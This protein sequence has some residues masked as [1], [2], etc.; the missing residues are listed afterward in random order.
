MAARGRYRVR[1]PFWGNGDSATA[2]SS[3]LEASPHIEPAAAPPE[4]VAEPEPRPRGR[5]SRSTLLTQAIATNALAVFCLIFFA[6]LVLNVNTGDGHRRTELI[7]L[8]LAIALV[9]TL[10]I[11]LLR[12]Q[13]APLERLVS[14]MEEIDLSKPG[15]RA[16]KPAGATEDVAELI[17]SFNSMIERLEVE[18]LGKVQATVDAQETERA[19]VARDLHDEAN[20]AL[21]AVI[22][23]LQA[24]AQDAPPDLAAEINEA[25]ELAGQAM[26]E[27]LQVVRRLRPT[28]LDLG[29][30]G[31]L[32][33]Q[34]S[35]FE[36]RTG[37][38]TTFEFQGDHSHRLGD[39]RE[40]AIYRVV[41]EA[42]SNTVQHA[43]AS[44]VEVALSV[45]DTVVL[46]VRDNGKGFDPSEPTG[47]FG[48]TGMRERAMMV[49][50]L[51]EIESSPGAGTTLR[52][53][54]P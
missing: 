54:M 26:E 35:E 9:L 19:R 52:M 11:V 14:T 49:N 45:A 36:D 53:E 40:L 16:E 28:T 51:L 32:S 38:K 5:T 46:I 3:S 48:V 50:G 30:R 21:T 43:D 24:A 2:I 27:L 8:M 20:Q 47:R 15:V 39:E 34:V 41:Q 31:A 18:R 33:A 7:L 17:D 42:L 37:I 22:L 1:N 4:L 12:R 29:L 13:F 10:N 6:V 23:R 25:K 44:R